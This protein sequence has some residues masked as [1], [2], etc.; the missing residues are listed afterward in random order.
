M[1][2]AFVGYM[3][4]GKTTI[5]HS[6]IAGVH[7]WQH[8]GFSDPML[9]AMRALG[10]PETVITDKARWNDPL[11]V[12]SGRT[13]RHAM[14]TFGTEWGRKQMHP[15]FWLNHGIERT[16]NFQGNT[17]IDNVRFPNE[18]EAIENEGGILIAL[19]RKSAV[20][21]GEI[22]ESEQHIDQLQQRCHI[23]L[24]NDGSIKSATLILLSVIQAYMASNKR[25]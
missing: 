2:F 23:D 5:A 8:I 25:L 15:D 17:F 3:G 21:T 16:R 4:S 14:Q 12:L 1:I 6:A 11:P 7:G 22:H 9:D 20:P 13:L 10:V 24:Y 19:R 18:F